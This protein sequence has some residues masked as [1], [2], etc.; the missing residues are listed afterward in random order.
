M[1]RPKLKR[2]GCLNTSAASL[3]RYSLYRPIIRSRARPCISCSYKH[4]TT[5]TRV[6]RRL[7]GYEN[8]NPLRVIKIVR[9]YERFGSESGHGLTVERRKAALLRR[10]S[11]L[12][13]RAPCAH[14]KQ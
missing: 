7:V 3:P 12:D 11:L 8:A 9:R 2:E 10:F 14:E 13:G 1:L 6:R 5:E 4:L